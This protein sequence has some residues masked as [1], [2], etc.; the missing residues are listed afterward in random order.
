MGRRDPATLVNRKWVL[1]WIQQVVPRIVKSFQRKTL[2]RI[3]Q[4]KVDFLNVALEEIKHVVMS[5]GKDSD[6]ME[7]LQ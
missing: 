4:Q 7:V 3:V 6:G 2:L 5:A 1:L